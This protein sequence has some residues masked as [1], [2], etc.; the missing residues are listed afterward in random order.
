[1]GSV[2]QGIHSAI[3]IGVIDIGTHASYNG[4]KR[5]VTLLWEIHINNQ[6][7]P[8]S[9]EYPYSLDKHAELRLHLESWRGK[10]FTEE[11]L[12]KFKLSNII[13]VPCKL[14]IRKNIKDLKQVENIYRFPKEEE[15]PISDG[16]HIYLNL[17]DET[18]YSALD[19]I[20]N[21]ILKKIKLSP[22]YKLL[23]SDSDYE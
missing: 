14:E 17:K 5:K 10:P 6:V 1:M 15:I 19:C 7:K 13:G 9:R 20:P 11:E 3:C 2:P 4:M 21:Y 12:S 18:T 23:R 22:E 16:K 8:F